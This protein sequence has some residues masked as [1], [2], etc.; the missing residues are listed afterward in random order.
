MYLYR[1]YCANYMELIKLIKYSHICNP[2]KCCF[3]PNIN[4]ICREYGV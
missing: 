3:F 4:K 1:I 2:I